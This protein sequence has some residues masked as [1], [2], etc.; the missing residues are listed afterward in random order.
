VKEHGGKIEVESSPGAGATFRVLLPAAAEEVSTQA[1][2]VRA[3]APPP[4]GSAE[5]RGHSVFIVD[6]EESIREIVQEGLAAR[7]MIVEGAASSEE[8]LTHLS[9]HHYEFVLCDFNLP[10]LDGEQLFDR[11][12]SQGGAAS[13]RFV[14]MSGALFD[15]AQ[16][17]KFEKKGASVLQKPFHVAGL[18]TLLADLLQHPNNAEQD[19]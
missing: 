8:A 18:A 9:A 12:R 15:P 17:S 2:T 4:P 10:G 16:I 3:I 11:V 5:L 1:N 7:G 6:D 13:P 19:S 14:F